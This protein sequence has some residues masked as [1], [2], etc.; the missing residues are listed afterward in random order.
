MKMSTEMTA[1]DWRALR[2]EVLEAF[3]PG[4]PISE[5]ELFAGRSEEIQQLEDVVSEQGRHA[6]IYGER[7]V[8]KTSIA[9]TFHRKL[10]SST[11]TVRSICVN[12]DST[13]DFT[14]LWR[15]VFRRIKTA[16]ETASGWADEHYLGLIKPDDVVIEL[17]S[18]AVIDVPI[19]IIDEYD[20]IKADEC[21]ILMTD[22]IKALSDHDINCT[23]ILVGVADSISSLVR[24]HA[25]ISRAVKQVQMPR[26]T[27]EELKEIVIKRL[28]RMPLQISDDALWRIAYFSK[29]LPFFTHSLGKFSAIAAIEAKK[30]LIKED[31]VEKAI[32]KCI[33]DTDYT[34]RESYSRAHERSKKKDNIFKDVMAAC[35][36]TEPDSV[37][38]FTAAAVEIPLSEIKGKT[39]QV[40]SFSYH[41]NELC[42][43]VRGN[44]LVKSGTK[45]NHRF[46][47]ADARMQPYLILRSMRD[48]VI[49]SQLLDK[50]A[51]RRQP[52]LSSDF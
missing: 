9:S 43:D 47:F 23:V 45:Q 46:S 17:A 13:D 25:S 51:I 20:R 24:D 16:D 12:A 19:V 4:R 33:E 27:Q 2:Q 6:I 26:M 34:I 38:K 28:K 40:P 41:L 29:G 11:R 32:T 5:L 50:Y 18:F 15:K 48:G 21:K 8:G 36:L 7:G 42:K 44:I 1:D 39:Y 37:G 22:A 3:T 49:D 52:R 30:L 10:N 35:A 31:D 14:S